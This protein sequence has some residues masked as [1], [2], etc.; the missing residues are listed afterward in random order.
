MDLFSF[1]FQRENGSIILAPP[2]FE[3]KTEKQTKQTQ[4]RNG[5]AFVFSA[6]VLTLSAGN[7]LPTQLLFFCFVFILFLNFMFQC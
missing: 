2:S 5:R 1:E 7:I 4:M 6:S 3:N